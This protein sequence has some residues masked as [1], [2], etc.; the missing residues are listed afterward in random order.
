MSCAKMSCFRW[1]VLSVGAFAA[2]T[3]G[4]QTSA[5]QTP[6]INVGHVQITGIPEDWS[7]HHLIFTDPGTEEEAIKAGRYEKW[8]KIVNDPRYVFQQLRRNGV[9]RGPLANDAAY[10][11]HLKAERFQANQP[12]QPGIGQLETHGPIVGLPGIG[13]LGVRGP[14]ARTRE[15]IT[16]RKPLA[17]SAPPLKADWA[18]AMTSGTVMPNAAPAKYSF[19]PIGTPSCTTDFVVYP[20]GATGTSGPSGTPTIIAYNNIYPGASPG[21]NA[22]GTVPLVYWAYNTTIPGTGAGTAPGAVT[23]S[24]VLSLDG[25]KV[26]FVQSDSL[27][28][29]LNLIVLKTNPG[30]GVSGTLTTPTVVGNMSLCPAATACMTITPINDSN[31]NQDSFSSPYVDYSND[32]AY[33]GDD[34]NGDLFQIKNVFNSN[35]T[36]GSPTAT[37]AFAGH[38]HT[39][40]SPLYDQTT[41]CVY[42]GD[43]NGTLYR[44]DSG[45]PGNVCTG[46]TFGT[47]HVVASLEMSDSN[48][49]G[50][51]DSVLV[52]PSAGRIYA[53]VAS[54]SST[55]GRFEGCGAAISCVVQFSTSFANG[56]QPIGFETLGNQTFG[57][58][59]F[60]GAVDN[61]YYSSTNPTNPSGSIWV[62]G[63]ESTFG[64]GA[65]LYQV[66]ING[67]TLG[68]P[69]AYPI[70]Y[71]AN[72]DT[73]NFATPITEFC[74][75]GGN[76]CLVSG[77][78]T[79]APAQDTIYFSI[80]Q[81]SSANGSG[82]TNIGIGSGCN[83]T[84]NTTGAGCILAVNVNNPSAPTV[85]GELDKQFAGIGNGILGCWG[86][87]SIIVDGDSPNTGAS[88]VYFI[89]F[90]G[91]VPSPL[92]PQGTPNSTCGTGSGGQSQAIQA[93]QA[94]LQ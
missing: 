18:V 82:P 48:D 69:V 10:V 53:F 49:G 58:Y 80:N 7:S 2:I 14:I 3:F 42:V 75:N 47:G 63:N 78:V 81:G 56:D 34:F 67:N 51:H 65:N 66:P 83:T 29:S 36:T 44:F 26:L 33:V 30:D 23:T 59:M 45:I 52:D 68:A 72:S 37:A 32:I 8:L 62:I 6:R 17:H 13:Q 19:A 9:I 76:P 79:Q 77:G 16:R 50:I 73:P 38:F 54:G 39:M 40:A 22:N 61:V 90:G 5:Q 85:S 12:G 55:A 93:K 1:L 4:I 27:G 87:G 94:T 71:E 25:T 24:P 74:N 35:A 43:V 91:N 28:T 88:E 60:D 64:G 57:V 31:P 70:G 21:C 15:P 46:A 84:D 11:Q 41:G 89:N 86:T 92:Y 20:T